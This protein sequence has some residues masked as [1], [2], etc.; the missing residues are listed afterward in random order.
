M[1]NDW[2]SMRDE[3]P[4]A[5]R[6]PA[7]AALTTWVSVPTEATIIEKPAV[8]PTTEM[9]N[10]DIDGAKP[11]PSALMP[12]TR[13]KRVS[14]GPALASAVTARGGTITRPGLRSRRRT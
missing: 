8:S 13:R 3:D 12:L 14:S 2:R 5:R 9:M 10:T 4:R 6:E 7:T 1:P 11:M